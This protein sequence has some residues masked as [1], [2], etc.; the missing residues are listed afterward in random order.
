MNDR[1]LPQIWM[2]QPLEIRNHLIRVFD[3]PR[4]GAAEIRDDYVVS[5]GYNYEDLAAVTG[6]AMATYVGSEETFS[7]LWELTVAKAKY[8]LDP[9]QELPV[10]IPEEILAEDVTFPGEVIGKR[11]PGRPA[12]IV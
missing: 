8:E 9:P 1:L 3:I 2:L 4:T 7:R 6:E 11:G 12:K 10:A 5:D